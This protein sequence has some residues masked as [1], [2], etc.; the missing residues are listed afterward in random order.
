MRPT[1][2]FEGVVIEPRAPR[3]QNTTM[4]EEGKNTQ[5][6]ALICAEIQWLFDCLS[7]KACCPVSDKERVET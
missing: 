6:R 3:N 1:S 7:E 4:G 5:S 2:T